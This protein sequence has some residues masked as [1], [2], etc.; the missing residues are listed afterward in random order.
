MKLDYLDSKLAQQVG[1]KKCILSICSAPP[2]WGLAS[3]QMSGKK[4]NCFRIT[5]TFICN[6]NSSEKWP[7]F[8]IGKSKQPHCFK[9][10]EAN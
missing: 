10:E 4:S 6:Q 3:S 1:I 2:D 7:I 9:K 8:Y 5:I